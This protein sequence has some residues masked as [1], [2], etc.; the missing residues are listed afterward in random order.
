MGSRFSG[1][2]VIV[3]GAAQG[4]GEATAREFA[5]EGA[6]VA[7]LDVNVERAEQAVQEILE[8]GEVAASGGVAKAWACDVT[9][10]AGVQRVFDEIVA[11]FG[12]VDVLVNNAGLTR[13]NLIFRMDVN[14][15]HTVLTVNLTSAYYCSRAAQGHMVKAKHGRIVNLS[16]Q[17]AL[18]NAGQANYAAAKAGIQGLTATL[19]QEL[20]RFGITVNAVAPGYIATSMTAATAQRVGSSFEEHQKTASA[21]IPLGRVGSP[22]EVASVISF[23]ASDA[24]SYVTGQTLY[25]N[26]GMR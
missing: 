21:R 15:W 17:S 18:G 2:R 25:V 24:A 3:T 19:A 26:G 13:D 6:K 4:I 23:L 8:D 12:G 22:D 10:E 7:V 11:E 5:A 16:S 9:D 20:G 1:Q 14:D